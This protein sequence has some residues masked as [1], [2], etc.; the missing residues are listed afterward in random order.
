MTYFMTR[1]TADSVFLTVK[2]HNSVPL[3]PTATI[4]PDVSLWQQDLTST[5]TAFRY[6][7]RHASNIVTY[8]G[9]IYVKRLPISRVLLFIHPFNLHSEVLLL[10]L[11]GILFFDTT[12]FRSHFLTELSQAVSVSCHLYEWQ[13]VVLVHLDL[14]VHF[15]S[16]LYQVVDLNIK[17]PRK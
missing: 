13:V 15:F 6:T 17:I 8:Q 7:I 1:N 4:L 11:L 9:V 3:S 14:Y 10:I 16:L 12:Q 2:S 5:L